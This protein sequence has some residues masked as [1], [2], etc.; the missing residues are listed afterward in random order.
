MMRV[1]GFGPGFLTFDPEVETAAQ[2]MARKGF[3][4]AIMLVWARILNHYLDRYEA[5][6]GERMRDE[7]NQIVHMGNTLGNWVDNLRSAE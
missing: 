3:N 1:L 5:E 7:H 6:N 4:T 2:A